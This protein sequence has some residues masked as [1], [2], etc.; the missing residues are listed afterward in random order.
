[1]RKRIGFLILISIIGAIA[2]I[3][4][5]IVTPYGFDKTSTPIRIVST[6]MTNK[7]AA[8]KYTQIV[9]PS[10]KI[11]AQMQAMESSFIGHPR[12]T[13]VPAEYNLVARRYRDAVREFVRQLMTNVWPVGVRSTV[14]ELVDETTPAITIANSLSKAKTL[15]DVVDI[16]SAD[17]GSN[18]AAQKL[19]IQLGLGVAGS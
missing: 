16:Y 1:M 5:Q 11:L 12:E 17:T 19:R 10:N 8:E 2:F 9:A 18:A 7:Q 6:E 13:K 15:G 14:V 3:V 4:A